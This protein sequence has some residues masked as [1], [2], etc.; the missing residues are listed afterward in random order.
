MPNFTFKVN[1]KTVTV[2]ADS[3]LALIWVLRDK[4]GITGPKFGCGIDVCKACTSHLDGAAIRPCVTT[5]ADVS[6]REVTTIEG[7]ANG[8]Q[9]HPVQ[10]AWI[11]LDVA[12]CG[13]CQPGQI[14]A[15]VDLLRRNPNP[16]DAD[17]DEMLNVCRCGTYP[18]IREAIKRAA[19]QI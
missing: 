15:A 8:D 9:L 14:M 7:L 16:T 2:D 11:D 10:Q 18:R 12:Q 1:G 19:G 3:D 6:G 5:L 4:L 17:I 13:Y